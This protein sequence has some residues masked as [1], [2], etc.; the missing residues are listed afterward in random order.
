M[1]LIVRRNKEYYYN[2]GLHAQ[3]PQTQAQYEYG[4]GRKHIIK[5][6]NNSMLSPLNSMLSGSFGYPLGKERAG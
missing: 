4:R 6:H 2:S 5:L 3:L 1:N